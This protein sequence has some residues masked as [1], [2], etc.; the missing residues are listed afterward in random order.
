[1]EILTLFDKALQLERQYRSAI[2]ECGDCVIMDNC[3]FHRAR[4]MEPIL[5]NMLADCGIRLLCQPPYHPDFN[6]CEFCF[7]QV[8]DFLRR[9][10]LSAE[11]ET[12]IAI[13]EAIFQ[14]STQNSLVFSPLWICFLVTF[15]SQ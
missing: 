15:S 14:I 11:H 4:F 9:Y 10:Q 5:K 13:T 1:M 3:G 7:R 6:S 12:K 2:I 8:K